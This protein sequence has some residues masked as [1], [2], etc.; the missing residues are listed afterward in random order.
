MYYVKFQPSSTSPSDRFWCWGSCSCCSCCDQEGRIEL[1]SSKELKQ[2]LSESLKFIPHLFQRKV[3]MKLQTQNIKLTGLSCKQLLFLSGS[4]EWKVAHWQP[5]QN[6]QTVW[7]CRWWVS[8][9][10]DTRLV[11]FF[12]FWSQGKLERHFSGMSWCLRG[13]AI[14]TLFG[15]G[16]CNLYSSANPCLQIILIYCFF[17]A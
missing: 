11:F 14:N 2:Y 17:Y 4:A 16:L 13:A 7:C 12:V 9:P 15:L 6:L 8:A 5:F 10:R 3:G 1:K